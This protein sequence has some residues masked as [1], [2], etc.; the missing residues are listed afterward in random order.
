MIKTL[1]RSERSVLVLLFE[2]GR[3][4]VEIVVY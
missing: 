3:I 4:V 1:L 2:I